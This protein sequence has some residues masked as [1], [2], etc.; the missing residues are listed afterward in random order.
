M[1]RRSVIA[2]LL[3]LGVVLGL[4]APASADPWRDRGGWREHEW[5]E[6]EWRRHAWREHERWERDHWRYRRPLYGYAPYH[7]YAPRAYYPAPPVYVAP[8]RFGVWLP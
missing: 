4:A 6:R 8:P 5:R 7:G 3:G 1:I 2:A